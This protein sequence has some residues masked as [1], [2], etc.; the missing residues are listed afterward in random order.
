MG[1]IVGLGQMELGRVL[2]QPAGMELSCLQLIDSERSWPKRVGVEGTK[3]LIRFVP[4]S[5]LSELELHGAK[6]VRRTETDNDAGHLKVRIPQGKQ[7]SVCHRRNST[8]IPTG[9]RCGRE[10]SAT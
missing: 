3:Y 9:G 5:R 8:A 2:D 6:L 7:E 1:F 4:S 10:M